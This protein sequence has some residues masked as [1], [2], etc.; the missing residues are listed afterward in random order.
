VALSMGTVNSGAH[1]QTMELSMGTADSGA[2]HGDCKQWLAFSMV[3]S[4][5][6]LAVGYRVAQKRLDG[7]RWGQ[8]QNR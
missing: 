8:T 7:S 1:V 4:F 6:H 5:C 3:F 2:Q